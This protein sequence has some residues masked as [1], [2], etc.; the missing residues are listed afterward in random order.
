MTGKTI[1]LEGN[2]VSNEETLS[3]TGASSSNQP[4]DQLD[5]TTPS[6]V[7]N[8]ERSLK[9]SGTRENLDTA[10]QTK[11]SSGLGNTDFEGSGKES[12]FKGDGFE[13]MMRRFKRVSADK[14]R[15][16]REHEVFTSDSELRRERENEWRRKNAR[17]NSR[18]S[19]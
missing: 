3:K 11:S 1:R 19:R 5:E 15:E 18:N 12:A 14:N 13:K 10:L 9:K 16:A 4:L 2:K 7:S 8:A 17:H 6:L